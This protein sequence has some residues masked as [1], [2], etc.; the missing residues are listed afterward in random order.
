MHKN[1]DYSINKLRPIKTGIFLIE[2][3]FPKKLAFQIQKYFISLSVF[4]K[5][6]VFYITAVPNATY[7]NVDF[8]KCYFWAFYL[9]LNLYI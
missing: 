2:P 9:F 8:Q 1:Q 5:Y 3:T 7:D 4:S 6:K